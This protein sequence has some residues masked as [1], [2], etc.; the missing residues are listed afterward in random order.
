MLN[1]FCGPSILLRIHGGAL[2]YYGGPLLDS[3]RLPVVL[4]IRVLRAG[5]AHAPLRRRDRARG[6]GAA[7]H[8]T[9]ATHAI[10]TDLKAGERVFQTFVVMYS[11]KQ[12][13]MQ[14]EGHNHCFV[15]YFGVKTLFGT[16][17]S[18]PLMKSGLKKEKKWLRG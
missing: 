5:A 1:S 8:P 6:E 15:H 18:P 17:F 10:S 2:K 11:Q 14:V 3:A 16:L 7:V 12:W 4:T 13:F 9:P